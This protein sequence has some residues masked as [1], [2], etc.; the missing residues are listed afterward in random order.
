MLRV[1]LF[2]AEVLLRHHS[3][4]WSLLLALLLVSFLVK[5]QS[6]VTSAPSRQNLCPAVCFLLAACYIL[7][8]LFDKRPAPACY[9]G[10]DVSQQMKLSNV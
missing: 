1:P 10:V 2:T 5:A 6:Y 8:K 4:L 9:T 3:M 7:L